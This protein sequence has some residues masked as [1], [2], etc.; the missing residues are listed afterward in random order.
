LGVDAAFA[1]LRKA[2]ESGW[3]YPNG[4]ARD[5][6]LLPLRRDPRFEALERAGRQNHKGNWGQAVYRVEE[7]LRE[8][9]LTEAERSVREHLAAIERVEGPSAGGWAVRAR[10]ALAGCLILQR[11]FEEAETLLVPT[12][13][14]L[15]TEGRGGEEEWRTLALLVQCDLGL[16]RRDAALAHIAEIIEKSHPGM[17]NVEILYAQ[18][19]SEAI[20]GNN[21]AAL[22]LLAQSSE[23][24]LAD[25]ERLDHD[26][27]FAELRPR[28]QFQAIAL[29][30]RKRAL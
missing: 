30:V 28:A 24:G 12:V 23:L 21:E 19:E 5:P 16:G 2:I 18:A 25:A 20:N 1:F 4:F 22:Q 9:R 14:A 7:H 27:A 13:A 10:W 11:R 15:R 17:E 29:A 3:D 26:L 8:G 6:L